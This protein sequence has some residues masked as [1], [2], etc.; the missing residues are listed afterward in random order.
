LP[1]IKDP[2]R[3]RKLLQGSARLEFWP[4]YNFDEVYQF[5]DEA[6]KRLLT[7]YKE[8]G[9][10][11]TEDTLTSAEGKPTDKS[12][13]LPT[14][15]SDTGLLARLADSAKLQETKQTSFEEYAKEHPLYAYLI[16]SYYPDENNQY[17]PA[18]TARV[19]SAAIK[20]TARIN[21]MLKKV[22]DV[23]LRICVYT[24]R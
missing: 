23:F 14:N 3:V 17:R 20:D 2:D 18:N 1:G 22:K 21:A 16:P 10:I 4:T 6:D 15:E 13:T 7:I 11:S 24:G 9:L 8:E 12:D 19:G 5:F